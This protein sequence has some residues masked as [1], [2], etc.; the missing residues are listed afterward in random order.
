[1]TMTLERSATPSS[2]RS[3]LLAAGCWRSRAI[4]LAP[5]AAPQGP[6]PERQRGPAAER[7]RSGGTGGAERRR[8]LHRDHRS[9][10][11]DRSGLRG[12]AR[13]RST[14]AL[15]KRLSEG[16][17]NL[18]ER[19]LAL[20]LIRSPRRP[21]RPRHARPRPPRPRKPR[22][23]RRRPRPRPDLDN[24]ARA[25]H[26]RRPAGAAPWLPAK[27]NARPRQATN[28]ANP[29]AR[30]GSVRRRRQMSDRQ[31]R[32]PSRPYGSRWHVN[33]AGSGQ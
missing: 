8:K 16:I 22:R 33:R 2:A 21:R 17:S 13:A 19:A 26:A 4:V 3:R 5:A 25:S 6:D 14:P 27:A 18:R 23:H 15:H 11:K 7:L 24:T 29:A 31:T 20:A 10:Q 28:R 32:A 1:M 9:D 12:A 30:T